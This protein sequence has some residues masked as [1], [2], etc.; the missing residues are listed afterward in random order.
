MSFITKEEWVENTV[1]DMDFKDLYRIAFDVM[2]DYVKDM[3]NK[4]F[5]EYLIEQGYEEELWAINY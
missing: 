1:E 3:S 4:D 2:F 5:K